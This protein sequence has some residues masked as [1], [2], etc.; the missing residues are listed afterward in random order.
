MY[1]KQARDYMGIVSLSVV[2]FTTF[3]AI[4]P[5]VVCPQSGVPTSLGKPDGYLLGFQS[6]LPS[7]FKI[8]LDG[9]VTK[10]WNYSIGFPMF[11]DNLFA[12]D[13]EKELIYLGVIDKFLALDLTTGKIEIEIPLKPPNLQYFWNY[14]YVQKDNAIYGVCTGNNAWNWCR[15]KLHKLHEHKITVDFLYVFPTD[16]L[17]LGP[18]DDLYYMDKE[19]QSIWYYPGGNDVFGTNYSTGNVIF[20]GVESLYDDKNFTHDDCIV[21]DH[22]L[23]RTFTLVGSDFDPSYPVLAELHPKPRNETI[24]M[25]LPADVRPCNTGTCKYD[26]KTHT[27]IALMANRTTDAVDDAYY[28]LLL[29]DVVGLTYEITPLPGLRKWTKSHPYLPITVVKFIPMLQQP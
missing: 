9:K 27:I 18:L 8:E 11:C 25:K 2:A 4:L 23:N 17:E 13:A 3:F 28:Y 6:N 10:L 22:S 16:I 26:P 19:H 15:I 29:I 21:H 5:C 14:D 20:Y 24:L 7:L 1:A 12:V